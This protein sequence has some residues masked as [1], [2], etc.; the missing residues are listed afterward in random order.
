MGAGDADPFAAA[1]H[2]PA[3]VIGARAERYAGS[4]R[5]GKFRV[6]LTDG[7][8]IDDERSAVYV[9]SRVEIFHVYTL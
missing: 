5:F 8:G 3:E 9:F 1:A 4:L 7:G 6:V 2:Q